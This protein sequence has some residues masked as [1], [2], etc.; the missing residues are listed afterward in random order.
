MNFDKII[1]VFGSIVVLAMVATAVQSTNTSSII[2]SIGTTFSDS[3]K[4][5]RG[6]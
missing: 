1:G 6:N 5:A 2:E 3:I 4:A